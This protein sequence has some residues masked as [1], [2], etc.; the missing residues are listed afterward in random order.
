MDWKKAAKINAQNRADVLIKEAND[1]A[2]TRS[3]ADMQSEGIEYIAK[4]TRHPNLSQA[5]FFEFDMSDER[6]DIEINADGSVLDGFF[7]SK[8]KYHRSGGDWESVTENYSISRSDFWKGRRA[9]L[10]DYGEVEGDWVVENFWNGRKYVTNAWPRNPRAKFLR[11]DEVPDVCAQEV[12]QD[13]LGKYISSGRYEAY[14]R[15]EY[16]ALNK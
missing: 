6:M 16:N 8:S 12:A 4:K 11:V 14:V 10:G 1:R 13:F 7:H 3:Q 9:P 2:R 5:V 15:E